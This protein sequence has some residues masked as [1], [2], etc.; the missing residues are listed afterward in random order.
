MRRGAGSAGRGVHPALLLVIFISLFSAAILP[1][2]CSAVP[3]TGNTS[4]ENLTATFFYSEHCIACT[5]ALPVAD[6]LATEYPSVSFVN[7]NVWN[8]TENES[9]FFSF[10]EA[11]G[12]PYPRYPTVF[13]SDGSFFEGGYGAISTDLPPLHLASPPTGGVPAVTEDP[14]VADVTVNATDPP[15]DPVVSSPANVTVVP[16]TISLPPVGLVIAAG[17]IDGINL[18]GGRPHISPA[19]PCR[20][21][22]E[23]ADA[24]LRGCLCGGHLSDLLPRR[25]WP[26]RRGPGERVLWVFLLR[27]RGHCSSPRDGDGGGFVPAGWGKVILRIS[28]SRLAVVRRIALRG[29]GVVSAFLVG[30]VVSLIELPCTG[31]GVYLA[32]LAMLSGSEVWAATGLLVLYNLMF[33]VPLLVIITAAVA[34]FPPERM[35]VMRLEYRQVLR[36]A[37]G[38]TLILLGAAVLVWFSV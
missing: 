28:S 38:C 11:Y 36:R 2:I 37:G 25:V 12:I 18:C 21:R 9:L 16:A 30:I 27:R 1:G 5:K 20:C 34:G 15:L 19:H 31:G 32:I 22:G 6:R 14:V 4:A 29:G 33:V 8:S 13:L 24:P 17:L 23:G 26:A 35:S 7:Y 10:G 3:V